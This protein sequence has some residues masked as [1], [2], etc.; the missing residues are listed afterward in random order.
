[1]NCNRSFDDCELQLMRCVIFRKVGVSDWD[2]FLFLQVLKNSLKI[3]Y[4]NND[5]SAIYYTFN[6][7]MMMIY[8]I[9]KIIY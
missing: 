4:L 5:T 9:Y 1:M 3:H 8:E 7:L 6:Y 2:F